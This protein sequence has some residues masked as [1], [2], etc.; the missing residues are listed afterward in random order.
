MKKRTVGLMIFSFI[1]LVVG[2]FWLAAIYKRCETI[3]PIRKPPKKVFAPQVPPAPPE[4]KEKDFVLIK[5][6]SPHAKWYHFVFFWSIALME[7]GIALMFVLAAWAIL[8]LYRRG[9][10]WVYAALVGDV[11]YKAAVC[12]YLF[13]C[14]I[15]L[16][17][18]TDNKNN[19]L[20]Y[21]MPDRSIYST[22]SSYL[23]GVKMYPPAGHLFA[24]FIYAAVLLG[25]FLYFS[26]KGVQERFVR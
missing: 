11:I 5:F 14:A 16:A 3:Y 2:L 10:T 25:C 21:Y 7:M 23:S 1:F 22:V 12:L 4:V 13:L 17:R 26:R 8:R 18:L 20:T 6:L 15:P 19:M 24:A 9:W